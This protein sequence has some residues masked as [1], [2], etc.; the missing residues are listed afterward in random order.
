MNGLIA[1]RYTDRYPHAGDVALL[2]EGDLAGYERDLL[3][4]WTALR[5]G[6]Q[7]VLVNVWP[8]GTADGIYSMADAI[9]RAI[10]VVVIEDRDYRTAQDAEKECHGKKQRREDRGIQIL[11]WRAWKRHEIENYFLEPAVLFAVLAHAF[12]TRESEVEKRFHHLISILAVDQAAQHALYQMRHP[13]TDVGLPGRLPPGIPR[14]GAR[15][16]WDAATRSVVAPSQDD[17]E[18]H[19]SRAIESGEK[20]LDR[21]RAADDPSKAIGLFRDT[22]TR[23]ARLTP[24]DA[25]W[26][27]D[28]AGKELLAYLRLWLAAE[29]GWPASPSGDR[30]PVQWDSLEREERAR[31][32]RDIEWALQPRFVRELL[33]LLA[34]DSPVGDWERAVCREWQEVADMCSPS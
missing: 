28:W 12:H 23:W 8:C 20:A 16:R 33:T 17:V 3:E 15:P 14:K 7:G 9:G 5:L 6:G 29:Y 32:H 27:T 24:D 26:R 13:W 21:A 4:T 1:Q 19:L 30:A 18:Q 10:P 31:L 34:K 2:C 11:A 22:C 25:E